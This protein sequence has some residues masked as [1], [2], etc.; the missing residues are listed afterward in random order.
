MTPAKLA[1]YVRKKTRTNATTFPD[2]DILTFLEPRF[3]EIARRLA[4]ESG[5]DKFGVPQTT[6]LVANQREYPLPS[7]L[8]SRIKRVE[9]KLDGENFIIVDELDLP[10][11]RGT[12]DETTITNNFA[13]LEGQAKYDLSRGTL[14]IYSGT[15]TDVSNGLKIFADVYPVAPTDLTSTTDMSVDPSTT[16]LGLP[17]EVHKAL[18]D[19]IVIDWK[20]SQEKPIPL[21]EKELNYEYHL[22]KDIES[23]RRANLDRET[24][25]EVPSGASVWNDGYDL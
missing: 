14:F 12:T 16:Q 25:S 19:G 22:Q 11:Y 18:A 7:D 15:I 23:A 6:D 1:T 20:E 4:T 13:N 9:A 24:K 5:E 2:A 21:S 3:E 10:E 17:R 8:L